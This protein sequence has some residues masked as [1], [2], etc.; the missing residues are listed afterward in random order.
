[1]K[2][3]KMKIVPN[4]EQKEFL[5]EQC[6]LTRWIYNDLLGVFKLRPSLPI[7]YIECR[8]ELKS[9]S[10]FSLAHLVVGLRASEKKYERL[11]S[12]AG[13]L[14]AKDLSVT[15]QE[16]FK[17]CKHGERSDLKFRNFRENN[18]FGICSINKHLTNRLD[19]GY[20]GIPK[21]KTNGKFSNLGYIKISDNGELYK[22]LGTGVVKQIKYIKEHDTWFVAL[23]VDGI[24]EDRKSKAGNVGIDLGIT[25][26]A[27]TSDGDEYRLPKEPIK[28][29][30]GRLKHYQRKLSRQRGGKGVFP[31][32][33]YLDTKKQIQKC[34][35]KIANARKYWQHSLSNE[36]TLKKDFIVM[37]DLSVK[38]MTKSAKGTIKNPGTKV[39]L[40]SSL[41]RNILDVGFYAIKSMIDYK[42]KERGG[43]LV[44]VNP[45][46]TSQTCSKCGCVNSENRKTQEAF[47][48]INCG[49]EEN[50]DFNAAKNI[51][52]LGI[53]K[54]LVDS[55]K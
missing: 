14:A 10:Y 29:W 12:E 42:S 43:K 7:S 45:K 37:E 20:I 38:R 15:I 39:K 50:A 48:C 36:I 47:K 55:S 6:R 19:D 32:N 22:K 27:I 8:T 44:L 52:N 28:Y 24:T 9:W 21:T 33:R 51:L 41:N 4:K 18:S 46:Y 23:V 54:N 5:E 35:E 53:A 11:L 30:N 49:H 31:S 13:Q 40:K 34:H 25:I 26:S 2:T 17:R 16:Y 3:F 1:M